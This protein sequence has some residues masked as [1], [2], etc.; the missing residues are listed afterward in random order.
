MKLTHLGIT[1]CL[2]LATTTTTTAFEMDH[3]LA[4]GP[5]S[6]F[7]TG[8]TISFLVEDMPDEDDQNVNANLHKA[9]GSLVKTIKTWSS[10]SVD[11]GGDEFPFNW[12][13]DVTETGSYY[14]EISAANSHEDITQSYPFEIQGDA[15]AGDAADTT[16]VDD[17]S[18][19]TPQST[20][21][22]AVQQEAQE[23]QEEPEEKEE[24]PK[25]KL[26]LHD[27]QTKVAHISSHNDINTVSEPSSSP[28]KEATP[29]QI[30]EFQSQPKAQ[31]Q[32]EP[33]MPETKSNASI[34]EL[35]AADDV[36]VAEEKKWL[37]QQQKGSDSPH[38]KH[39]TSS[40]KDH[41]KSQQKQPSKVKSTHKPADEAPKKKAQKDAGKKTHKVADKPASKDQSAIKIALPLSNKAPTTTAKPNKASTDKTNKGQDLKAQIKAKAKETAAKVK[42]NAQKSNEEEVSRQKMSLAQQE[43]MD[44]KA[45]REEMAQI[46]S[47]KAASSKEKRDAYRKVM[48]NRA[49]FAKQGLQ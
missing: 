43:A 33:L 14:V 38:D 17:G 30:P 48:M 13:V 10:Q 46:Q 4:P 32:S 45:I 12:L 21:Y 26:S 24:Q 19:V 5:N 34:K 27:E 28:A 49:R 41:P 2:L 36:A 3:F 22:E 16:P 37:A 31:L 11:D 42:E 8:D 7:K 20:Q 35:M 39:K 6:H 25:K 44:D 15:E 29:Q 18:Q 47:S 23:A 1:L 40:P 9:D